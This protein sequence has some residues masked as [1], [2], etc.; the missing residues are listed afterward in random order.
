[1]DISKLTGSMCYSLTVVTNV[2]MWMSTSEYQ[3]II[4]HLCSCVNVGDILYV[5]SC[6]NVGDILYV[7]SCVNGY[8]FVCLSLYECG[9]NLCYCDFQ[10]VCVCHSGCDCHFVC[11]HLYVCV[12]VH[13]IWCPLSPSF[14]SSDIC[15][16]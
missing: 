14:T 4:L 6:V 8:H 15:T 12:S 11:K 2:Y 3:S 7:C 13:L 9:C 5:W 1:M 10:F 16:G